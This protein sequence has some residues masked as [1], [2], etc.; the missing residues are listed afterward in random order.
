MQQKQ[1]RVKPVSPTEE[2]GIND[3]PGL[4]HEAEEMGSKAIS[5]E[6][7]VGPLGRLAGTLN[8]GCDTHIYSGSQNLPPLQRVGPDRRARR[9][10]ATKPYDRQGR[11]RGARK[12]DDLRDSTKPLPPRSPQNLS[13]YPFPRSA[14]GTALWDGVDRPTWGN[15]NTVFI[16]AQQFIMGTKA[17]GTARREY[18]CVIDSQ[19][20]TAYLPR[21]GDKDPGE[22]NVSVG[23]LTQWRD[24]IAANAKTHRWGRRGRRDPSDLTDSGRSVVPGC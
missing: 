3:D 5:G 20:G 1:R 16:N 4:E 17:D 13:L 24:Y 12:A 6:A 11:T 19:G 15:A 21:L 14:G 9:I 2:A 22:D 10:A 18:Q 23:H 7:G 8:A